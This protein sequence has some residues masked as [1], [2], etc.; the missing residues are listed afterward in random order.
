MNLISL[1]KDDELLNRYKRLREVGRNLN[2]HLVTL[3]PRAA[4]LECGKKLG[5]VQGKALV[6]DDEEE[7]SILFDYCLHNYR[8]GG[9]NIIERYLE[10]SPT[11]A[12]ADEMIL[13]KGKLSSYY[14][15][16]S[17]EEVHQGRGA[18]L[19]DILRNKTLLLMDLGIGK[20]AVPGLLFAGR[21]IPLADFHMTTGTFIPV[22]NKGLIEKEIMSIVNKF[23]RHSKQAGDSIFSPGQEAAL[24]AQIIRVLL[25]A[26]SLD[27]MIYQDI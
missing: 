22:S 9:K 7:L 23:L 21:V 18:T 6:L 26:G 11:L 3:V 10:T 13:L 12:T 8:R 19:R 1:F 25:R 14:S 27:R 15:L 16:F 20:S 4:L 17:I 24:A 2:N 5:L